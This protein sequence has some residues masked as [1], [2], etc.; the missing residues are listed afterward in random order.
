MERTMQNLP[1]AKEESLIPTSKVKKPIFGRLFWAFAL[2]SLFIVIVN[3]LLVI[4]TFS[5]LFYM[6]STDEIVQKLT[7]NLIFLVLFIAIPC[8]FL[9]V[10]ISSDIA[11]PIRQIGG[12]IR[13]LVKGNLDVNIKTARRDEFGNLIGLFNGLVSRMKSVRFRDQELSKMK[14]KFIT[15]ASH[16]LRTP[17][18]GVGWGLDLLLKESAGALNEEQKQIVRICQDRNLEMIG[19][20]N[21]LMSVTQI[22][23]SDLYYEFQEVEIDTLL[24]KIINEFSME[25]KMKNI[26]IQFENKV[27]EHFKIVADPNRLA[28][29]FGNIIEN[30]IQYGDKNTTI[31]VAM[32]KEDNN[33]L[34]QIIN[35]GIG[36]TEDDQ[37]RIFS[38]FFRGENALKLKPNGSGLGLYIA[39]KI[40]SEHKGKISFYGDKDG[41]T[42]FNIYLPI[43]QELI[44]TK[45]KTEEFLE[46]I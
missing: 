4:Y 30:A 21:D 35:Q 13:E 33:I 37:E 26:G 17:S 9:S 24:G 1:T 10:S 18:S 27:A 45:T 46:A 25:A 41:K 8:V 11:K 42:T 23:E 7:G 38:K 22:E 12:S 16:Q 39:R 15:V 40:I 14:S 19:I 43:H 2:L 32:H 28:T 6:I 3:L 29:V 36:I 44:A 34:I 5:D 20:V 31:E